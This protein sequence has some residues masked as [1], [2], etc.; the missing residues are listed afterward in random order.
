M[1]K[2]KLKKKE[3]ALRIGR[4]VEQFSDLNNRLNRVSH[5]RINQGVQLEQLGR[6][7]FGLQQRFEGLQA[8]IGELVAQEAAQDRLLE[9]LQLQASEPDSGSEALALQSEMQESVSRLNRQLAS[10]DE[11][12]QG[13][14]LAM[15]GERRTVDQVANK[16]DD[17]RR[18]IAE[19]LSHIRRLEESG[20]ELLVSDSQHENQIRG[21]Q[22]DIVELGRRVDQTLGEREPPQQVSVQPLLEQ[23]EGLRAQL[24]EKGGEQKALQQRL[25]ELANRIGETGARVEKQK[26][27]K[28]HF[29]EVLEDRLARLEGLV[30]DLQPVSDADEVQLAGLN[31]RLDQVEQ[32]LG[33]LSEA[34]EASAQSH[35]MLAE[36]SRELAARVDLL[37]GALHEQSARNG[38]LQELIDQLREEVAGN[39]RSLEER[40]A[41]TDDRLSQLLQQQSAQPDPL[42]S[43]KQALEEQGQGFDRTLELLKQETRGLLVKFQ[44]LEMEGQEVSERLNSLAGDLDRQAATREEIG[45]TLRVTR[46]ELGRKIDEINTR[47]GDT[48]RQL[49]G[50][51]ESMQDQLRQLAE[52]SETVAEQGRYGVDIKR[53]IAAL[54]DDAGNLKQS[55][56]LLGERLDGLQHS[57]QQGE[58]N[59]EG[60]SRQLAALEQQQSE[61]REQNLLGID[62]L[63]QRVTSAL[64]R[65]AQQAGLSEGLSQR[66]DELQVSLQER[67]EKIEERQR[68]LTET[69]FDH[70]ER[71]ELQEQSNH[72]LSEQIT[73]LHSQQRDLLEQSGEQKTFLE[74]MTSE[75][76]KRQEASEQIQRR[77][78]TLD[79]KVESV[80]ST[81]TYHTIAMGGLLALLLLGAL[82]GYNY[83]SGRVAGVER[84]LTLDLMKFGENYVTR[85]ELKEQGSGSEY[86]ALAVETLLQEQQRLQQRLT[87]FETRFTDSMESLE[88]RQ[89][90]RER[91]SAEQ[92]QA[93]TP[94][95]TDQGE[96]MAAT[97]EDQRAVKTGDR[98][99][100]GTKSEPPAPPGEVLEDDS[101]QP[102]APSSAL[103]SWL[104]L[105]E[106]GGYT[107]QLIGVSKRKAVSAFAEKHAL[108]GDLA[109]V[110]TSREGKDWY[111][112]LQGRYESYR[113]ASKALRELPA[114]L[115][116]QQPWVRKMPATGAINAL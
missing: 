14:K 49:G 80:R 42:A 69:E 70:R 58:E 83:L 28:L 37:D 36:K 22:N 38:T 78:G 20:S 113:E 88:D 82:L 46:D 52:L 103:D 95:S 30:T 27:D 55:S 68:K 56:D 74:A 107:L 1:K 65:V 112:L 24:A 114:A 51:S 33:S 10:L 13:M 48:E 111:I 15:E 39:G 5:E 81:A 21:L 91:A 61:I 60:I 97:L 12:Q 59:R 6:D 35:R 16:A 102:Q 17:L 106:R 26:Q 47:L 23:I 7:S 85:N 108:Q 109:T 94:S 9:S 54:Q 90:L 89:A 8:R 3:L 77:V 110:R 44:S 67:F 75:H 73:E 50:Q 76:G 105:R 100:A 2:Q 64:E 32:E 45:Q 87:E 66:L 25:L 57:Q 18:D 62:S 4:L 63:Q 84:D 99:G 11:Q 31:Q 41:S 98:D 40:L 71:L 93:A 34:R 19:V 43:L 116:S 92:P 96:S 101:R 86:D 115:K 72:N 29:D 79:S 53:L 104:A